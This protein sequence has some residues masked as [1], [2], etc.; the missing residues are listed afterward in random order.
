MPTSSSIS[1]SRTGVASSWKFLA[2]ISRD[3]LLSKMLFSLLTIIASTLT[4]SA[5]ASPAR[6]SPRTPVPQPETDLKPP[7]WEVI[8]Y[9]TYCVNATSPESTSG[10]DHH[11]YPKKICH[12]TFTVI[13]SQPYIDG[14]YW[15]DVWCDVAINAHNYTVCDKS[16]G[17]WSVGAKV[18]QDKKNRTM[19]SVINTQIDGDVMKVAE[20]SAWIP[21]TNAVPRFMRIS[22]IYSTAGAY[23]KYLL[24]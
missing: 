22:N 1:G 18:H 11:H 14:F 19:L 16:P 8:P 5:L 17:W 23:V 24:L 15:F 9:D 20:G 13:C 4:A 12:A 10:T 3:Q 7:F 6:S 21:W 2:S